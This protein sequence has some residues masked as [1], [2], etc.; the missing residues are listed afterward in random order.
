MSG[1]ARSQNALGRAIDPLK[2]VTYRRPPEG[3]LP[4]N[5][6]RVEDEE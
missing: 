6:L 5:P 2:R 1:R 4:S 3:A